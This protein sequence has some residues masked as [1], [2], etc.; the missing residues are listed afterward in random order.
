MKAWYF[1]LN[2][3]SALDIHFLVK[4]KRVSGSRSLEAERSCLLN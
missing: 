1:S 4:A 2:P 3:P